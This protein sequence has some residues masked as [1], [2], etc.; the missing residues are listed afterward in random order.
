MSAGLAGRLR[1]SSGARFVALYLAL[2]LLSAIPLFA[3]IYHQTDR[4]LV[5]EAREVVAEHLDLLG[6]EHREG[7]IA[8]LAESIAET[9]ASGAAAHEAYLLVDGRGTPLAGNLSAWPPISPDE[10]AWT[11]LLLYRRA[12]DRP[13]VI[14]FTV[15]RLPGGHRL[16]VGRV[17]DDR[18][19]LRGALIT[20]LAS[21][22]LL[23]VPIALIGS[24]IMLKFMNARV[25][26]MADATARVASGELQTRIASHGTNDPFDRLAA[27]LNAM[28]ERLEGLVEE[29]R[30]VTDTLAHDLRSPL[31]RM[32]ATLER[33]AG[34]RDPSELEAA[35]SAIAREIDTMLKMTSATI[36]VSRAEAGIGRDEF[37]ALDVA[38]LVRDL[39]ELY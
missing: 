16:L 32:R 2:T 27:A 14:G 38:T 37:V 26:A 7:G 23:A 34:S 20:A 22:L 31:T 6:A 10:E 15:E 18:G 17:M 28:L 13:E 4:L 33:A 25:E 9:V 11:E 19:R 39:C 24:I 1:H 3:F 12:S 5:A 29:L 35:A 30:F 36:E 8:Q 21:A